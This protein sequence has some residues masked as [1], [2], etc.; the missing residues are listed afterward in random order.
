VALVTSFS[1]KHSISVREHVEIYR[2]PMSAT[3]ALVSAAISELTLT[4]E[5]MFVIT[6]EACRLRRSPKSSR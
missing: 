1:E 4:N 5:L 6:K 2:I 3:Q